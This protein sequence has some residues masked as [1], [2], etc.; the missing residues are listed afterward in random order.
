M[1]NETTKT[2]SG[3][4]AVIRLRGDKKNYPFNGV[5]KGFNY[6]FLAE[7]NYD[8]T[9]HGHSRCK[10]VDENGD[11]VWLRGTPFPKKLTGYDYMISHP[12]D[13]N[14]AAYFMV[15]EVKA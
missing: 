12:A 4:P 10:V 6:H 9:L 13:W 8:A 3:E 11:V 1:K 5:C 7:K 15:V 2:A 14:G